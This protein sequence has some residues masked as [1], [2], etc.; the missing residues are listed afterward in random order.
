MVLLEEKK[1]KKASSKLFIDKVIEE[2]SGKFVF[3]TYDAKNC[4]YKQIVDRGEL[5]S[6]ISQVI[7]DI[8]KRIVKDRKQ[9]EKAA[10]AKANNKEKQPQQQQQQQQSIGNTRKECSNDDNDENANNRDAI[11]KTRVLPVKKRFKLDGG[12]V[13]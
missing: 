6:Q 7:R 8:R 9:E 3:R 10:K 1:E 5:R 4:W 12:N 13:T 11:S 2:T